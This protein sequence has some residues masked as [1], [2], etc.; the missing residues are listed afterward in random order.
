MSV[1]LIIL[2]VIGAVF[3][4]GFFGQQL[5]N[6]AFGILFSAKSALVIIGLIVVVYL[7]LSFS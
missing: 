2:A 7:V 4:I 3:L 1:G 5:L 6:F